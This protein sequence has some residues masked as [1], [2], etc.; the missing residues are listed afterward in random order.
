MLCEKLCF[1]QKNRQA[2]T[3]Y[4][5]GNCTGAC[6]GKESAAAYNVRVKYAIEDLKKMLPSFAVIDK[7]RTEDEQS[8]LLVEEGKFYGMGYISHHADINAPEELKSVLQPYPSNDYILHMILSHTEQFP[9][10]K[11]AI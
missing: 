5:E 10:K 7:G 3:A 9:Q 8:C 11:I 4:E 1:I 2:C 6:V